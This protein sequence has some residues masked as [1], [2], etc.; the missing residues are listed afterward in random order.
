VPLPTTFAGVIYDYAVNAPPTKGV[1]ARLAA[2]SSGCPEPPAFVGLTSGMAGLYQVNFVI[3]P[4]QSIARCGF[5]VVSNLTLSLVGAS[6]YDGA[7][8]SVGPSA[9]QTSAQ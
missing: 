6:S 7:V 9:A 1:P 3:P 4:S 8:I 2:Y 5:G